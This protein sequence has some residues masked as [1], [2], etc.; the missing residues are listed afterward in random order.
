M[1][2]WDELAWLDGTAQ[3]ELVWRHRAPFNWNKRVLGR[4]STLLWQPPASSKAQP[5]SDRLYRPLPDDVG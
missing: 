2:P 1:S 3:A 4:A 5:G